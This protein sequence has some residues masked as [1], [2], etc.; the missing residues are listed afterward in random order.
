LFSESEKRQRF[1][2]HAK[3]T[4]GRAEARVESEWA[5]VSLVALKFVMARR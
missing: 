3:K 4:I 2:I 1:P 5:K